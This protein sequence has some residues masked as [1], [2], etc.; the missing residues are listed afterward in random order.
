MVSS[1][2]ELVLPIYNRSRTLLFR[3][4]LQFH[5]ERRVDAV[6]EVEEVGEAGHSEDA[7]IDGFMGFN[8]SIDAFKKT[9][10]SRSSI[11]QWV[12]QIKPIDRWILFSFF[13]SRLGSIR[14]SF[15][16]LTL[17]MDMKIP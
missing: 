9:P 12:F 2:M 5:R 7:S 8:A 11:D 1:L 4:R 10:G 16:A 6:G 14:H 15:C 3:Q 13:S 17:Q